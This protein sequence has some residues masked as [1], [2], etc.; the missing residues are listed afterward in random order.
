MS[1]DGGLA[2]DITRRFDMLGNVG[3]RNFFTKESIFFIVKIMHKIK[4]Y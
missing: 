3:Q 2:I 1:F 4:E